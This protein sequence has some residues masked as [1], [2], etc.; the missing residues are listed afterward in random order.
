VGILI[1][2]LQYTLNAPVLN[3]GIDPSLAQPTRKQ[4]AASNGAAPNGAW[5]IADVWRAREDCMYVLQ[6]ISAEVEFLPPTK[7]E[8]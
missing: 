7:T 1:L 6:S 2:Q 8:K 4:P 3:G 5:G